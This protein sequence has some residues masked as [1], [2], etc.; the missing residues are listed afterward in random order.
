MSITRSPKR[1]TVRWT[2]LPIPPASGDPILS[3]SGWRNV[4]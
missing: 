4:S 1:E 3:I 2:G